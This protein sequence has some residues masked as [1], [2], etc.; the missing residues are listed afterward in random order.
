MT[1]RSRV[2]PT[3][4][5]TDIP[6]KPWSV[7][8]KER[9]LQE[10]LCTGCDLSDALGFP[11]MRVTTEQERSEPEWAHGD[12]S[13]ATRSSA[14]YVLADYTKVGQSNA[15]GH[16]VVGRGAH[17]IADVRADPTAL[18]KNHGCRSGCSPGKSNDEGETTR[19]RSQKVISQ[20]Y[21]VL[22]HCGSAGIYGESPFL[23]LVAATV[24]E[25]PCFLTGMAAIRSIRT[26]DHPAAPRLCRRFPVQIRPALLGRHAKFYSSRMTSQR[27]HHRDRDAC[28]GQMGDLVRL[29]TR[30]MCTGFDILERGDRWPSGLLALNRISEYKDR[31]AFPGKCF[32][33][34]LPADL[35]SYDE[36]HTL[37]GGPA[38]EGTSWPTN[39][40]GKVCENGSAHG[41]VSRD[42]SGTYLFAAVWKKTGNGKLANF[43]D[44]PASTLFTADFD[45]G[46]GEE[47]LGVIG[48]PFHGNK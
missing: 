27:S 7:N 24:P 28:P 1:P 16:A 35:S 43:T 42:E 45:G 48:C 3:G 30:L 46:D 25:I 22:F 10:G 19:W 47:E 38:A 5:E 2:I 9:N 39:G 11:R 36:G 8:G 12:Q 14:A 26:W 15:S 40:H 21:K 29:S 44:Y 20:S 33:R 23:S 41:V 18:T 37:L 31:L 6:K 13:G 32:A 4:G 34:E 17:L